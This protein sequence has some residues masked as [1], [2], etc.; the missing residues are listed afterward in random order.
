MKAT[1]LILLWLAVVLA[2]VAATRLAQLDRPGQ[3]LAAIVAL[4]MLAAIALTLTPRVRRLAFTRLPDRRAAA[5][6]AVPALDFR[7][8]EA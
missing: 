2:A 7:P 8:N 1:A 4:S 5:L 6:L 3:T